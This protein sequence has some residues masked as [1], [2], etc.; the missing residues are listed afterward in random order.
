MEA[1]L[2]G[3]VFRRV[4]MP[5][6]ADAASLSLMRLFEVRFRWEE[7]ISCLAG[8]AGHRR[9]LYCVRACVRVSHTTSSSG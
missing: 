2:P 3:D 7:I 8:V 5:P 1:P 6:N 9:S 4:P